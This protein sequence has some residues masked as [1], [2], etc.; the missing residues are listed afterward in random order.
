MAEHK[1]LLTKS[2][3]ISQSYPD[4]NYSTGN[5]IIIA[6]PG[7][8]PTYTVYGLN[9]EYQFQPTEAIV[10]ASIH[11]YVKELAYLYP[12]HAGNTYHQWLAYTQ[13]WEESAITYNNSYHGGLNLEDGTGYWG[14][15]ATWF[16]FGIDSTKDLSTALKYGFLLRTIASNGGD[17]FTAAS[18]RAEENYRPYINIT[19]KEAYPT[20][21]PVY[22]R[23]TPVSTAEPIRFEW[24]YSNE[25]FI[26]PEQKKIEIEVSEDG[27]TWTLLL[28]EETSDNYYVLLNSENVPPNTRYWRIR[29]T[30][31]SGVVGAWSDTAA[32]II[33]APPQ[34]GIRDISTSPLPVVTWN[35]RG[36][37]GF[38]VQ[39]GNYDSGKIY[40][41][42]TTFQSPVYISDG[43]TTVRIR[44]V[45]IYGLWSAW[46]EANVDIINTPGA[47]VSMTATANHYAQIAWNGPAGLYEVLRD[48]KKIAETSA[49]V[50]FDDLAIGEHTYQVRHILE[51]GNYTLS[52]AENVKIYCKVPMIT[53]AENIKWIFL[54][55]KTTALPV[56]HIVDN[57]E[58]YFMHYS[59][60]EYPVA[61]T[62]G[63]KTRAL[64]F[65]VAY[66][67]NEDSTALEELLG[68]KVCYKDPEG[69][70]IIGILTGLNEESGRMYKEY[71]GTIQ[72]TDAEE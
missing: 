71:S 25:A 21:E 59:G 16:R 55:K 58:I 53:D 48:G 13:E 49:Q 17:Q 15:T 40:G 8:A 27:L 14:K 41:T 72:A 66:G 64:R 68:K 44:A 24:S 22:P 60:R 19:T 36:Q 7:D 46:A 33:V 43:P 34:I 54:N 57:K 3:R 12:E 26:N 29:A 20:A 31:K 65:S 61:E 38:Q 67:K 39:I 5:D 30:S 52:N 10:D 37:R 4:T 23:N 69:Q 28:E 62:A 2:A 6:N 70:F 47:A 56:V 42:E 51:N 35:S 1:I 11:L 18:T 45:S 50:Y 63:Y 9:E 32:V